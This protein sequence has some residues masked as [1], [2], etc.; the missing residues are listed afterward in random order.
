MMQ[1]V[2]QTA[3]CA[4]LILAHTS[5]ELYC[6]PKRYQHCTVHKYPLCKCKYSTK[7]Y[8]WVFP[9]VVCL[10]PAHETLRTTGG[11]RREDTTLIMKHPIKLYSSF[12]KFMYLITVS[13]HTALIYT[14]TYSVS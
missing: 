6:L 3:S 10:V 1:L 11:G 2:T 14:D 4:R 5:H 13:R 12:V 8:W 9:E 7:M